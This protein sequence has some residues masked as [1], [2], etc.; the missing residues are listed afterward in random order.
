MN[1]TPKQ[2]QAFLFLAMRRRQREQREMLYI[3]AMGARGD[4]KAVEEQLRQ[5]ED[6]AVR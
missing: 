2:A 3:A 1:Y 5:W 4:P 6:G